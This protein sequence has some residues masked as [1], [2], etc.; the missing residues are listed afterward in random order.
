MLRRIV[1]LA[2]ASTVA[3]LGAGEAYAKVSCVNPKEEAALQTRVVQ[4]ELMVAALLCHATPRYNDFVTANQKELMR[5][6]ET[7]RGMF[8]RFY[9]AQGGTELNTFITKLAN[10][11]SKRSTRGITAFCAQASAIYDGA[12]AL[13]GGLTLA[14]FVA[15][16]PVAQLHGFAACTVGADGKPV[17]IPVPIRKPAS[18]AAMPASTE[19][20][21]TP[22]P[23]TEAH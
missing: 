20:A 18:I 14:S 7:L 22:A 5:A 23:E 6:H 17:S 19:P 9:G 10:D 8:K 1:T 15:V 12:A 3:L 21:E 13:T 16:Q 4:T 11:S 2:A